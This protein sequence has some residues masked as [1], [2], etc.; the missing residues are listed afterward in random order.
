M[1]DVLRKLLIIA[2]MVSILASGAVAQS[3]Q[4]EPRL[5]FELTPYIWLPTI[6]LRLNNQARNGTTVTTNLS[7]GAGDYLTK[8]NPYLPEL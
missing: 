5:Q 7:I 1:T 8:L 2:G 3:T 4:T 6:D